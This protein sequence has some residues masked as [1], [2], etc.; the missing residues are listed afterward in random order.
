MIITH[1]PLKWNDIQP[2]SSTFELKAVV[3]ACIIVMRVQ[4]CKLPKWK[5]TSVIL[6]LM[7]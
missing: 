5:D 1:E 2:N 3:I 4:Y 7:H 6:A